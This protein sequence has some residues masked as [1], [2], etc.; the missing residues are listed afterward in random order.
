MPELNGIDAASQIRTYENAKKRKR[1][2]IIGLTGHESEDIKKMCIQAGMD[3]VLE[4][5]IKK[6]EIIDILKNYLF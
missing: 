4:K 3:A 5:P 6:Q 1:V 2:P